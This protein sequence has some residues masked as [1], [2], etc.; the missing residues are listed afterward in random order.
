LP[1][2]K[3]LKNTQKTSKPIKSKKKKQEQ[4]LSVIQNESLKFELEHYKWSCQLQMI[5]RLIEYIDEDIR[6]LDENGVLNVVVGPFED[7]TFV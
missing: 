4:E 7:L 2:I 6:S 5:D 3:K 1:R